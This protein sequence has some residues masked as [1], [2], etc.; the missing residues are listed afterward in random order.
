MKKIA[1]IALVALMAVAFTSCK[2]DYKCKC[3]TTS[4]GVST[5]SY[6]DSFKETKKKAKDK[7]N[8]L[9]GETTT[10]GVTVKVDCEV[11]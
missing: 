1:P 6:S 10:L 5:T 7:C 11:E 9:D 2:K 4:N 3:T 8:G